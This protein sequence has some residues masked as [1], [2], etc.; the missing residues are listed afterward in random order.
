VSLEVEGLW[1]TPVWPAYDSVS[2]GPKGYETPDGLLPRV[3]TINRIVGDGTDALIRW[4]AD[5]E[6]AAVLAAC[7]EVFATGE[8]AGPP[9]FIAEVEA[10]LGTARQHVKKL[11]EAA[12]IGTSIHQMIQWTLRREIG[13]DAGQAPVLRD[14]AQWA[15]MAWQDWRSK[16]S[17]K[18]LRVEQ[19]IWDA[20]RGYAG[21]VDFIGEEDGEL[22]VDDWKSSKGIYSTHHLQLGAY[23]DAIEKRMRRKVKRAR[24]VKTPKTI[25]D[26]L[27][28]VRELGDMSYDYTKNGRRYVGGRRLTR[29][30]LTAAFD[31]ALTLNKL[32]VGKA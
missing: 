6:R 27:I 1:K 8:C 2:V 12:E 19:P 5:T 21:T 4:S 16:Q 15:F 25:G 28:Q 3:T 9:E 23:C 17:W 10:H 7:G 22:I 20:E 29:P 30:Q 32:L 14:E 13:E 26:E 18:V 11:A 31:A 24:L